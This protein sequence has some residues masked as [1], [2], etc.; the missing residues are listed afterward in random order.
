MKWKNIFNYEIQN[1][2]INSYKNSNHENCDNWI[3]SIK[4]WFLF[5]LWVHHLNV[6]DYPLICNRFLLTQSFIYS[7]IQWI[8]FTLQCYTRQYVSTC[9]QRQLN[10]RNILRHLVFIE[11]LWLFKML[12]K[13]L[14]YIKHDF[15]L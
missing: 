6:F 5:L 8:H 3:C 14:I 10:S 12:L 15:N 13:T 4:N 9:R 7:F 1:G 2:K 11:Y